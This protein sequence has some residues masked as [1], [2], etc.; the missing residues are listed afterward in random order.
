MLSTEVCRPERAPLQVRYRKE[1]F[2][3]RLLGGATDNLQYPV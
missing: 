2:G 3:V 1:F